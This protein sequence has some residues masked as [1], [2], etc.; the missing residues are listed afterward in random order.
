MGKK[1]EKIFEEALE[2][3]NNILS[4]ENDIISGLDKLDSLLYQYIDINKSTHSMIEGFNPILVIKKRCIHRGIIIELKN[5][6]ANLGLL[7][8]MIQGYKIK[9]FGAEL[10]ESNNN[11]KEMANK[12][13]KLAPKYQTI[14]GLD[15]EID[16]NW[17]YLLHDLADQDYFTNDYNKRFVQ[18]EE[19][20]ILSILKELEAASNKANID[21]S[22]FQS[23][24]YPEKEQSNHR[25]LLSSN[26]L[27]S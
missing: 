21:Y 6:S 24:S 14:S 1:L 5:I 18:K 26:V 13:V 7:K 12:L 16:R 27:K 23:R 3:A 19:N 20:K 2:E 22:I 25:R 17:R 10:E 15:K 11:V 8:D 9:K 4:I